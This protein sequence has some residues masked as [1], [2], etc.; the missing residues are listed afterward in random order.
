M[1]KIMEKIINIWYR[2]DHRINILLET[3][4]IV[5]LDCC[6]SNKFRELYREQDDILQICGNM[7]DIKY[8]N[9]SRQLVLAA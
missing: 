8:D 6:L 9:K 5:R 3:G 1:V 4:N 7:P 2:G